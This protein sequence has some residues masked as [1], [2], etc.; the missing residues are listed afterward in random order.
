MSVDPEADYSGSSEDDDESV[1]LEQNLPTTIKLLDEDG[2]VTEEKIGKGDKVKICCGVTPPGGWYG[3]FGCFRISA[4]IF[5]II[6][7]VGA[8]FVILC[9]VG[10]DFWGVMTSLIL[11]VAALMS[12]FAS[13]SHEGIAKQASELGN[14]NK[15]FADKNERFAKQIEALGGVETRLTNVQNTM[16]MDLDQLEDTLDVIHNLT[17]VRELNSML[18]CF[19]DADSVGGNK[20]RVLQGREVQDFFASSDAIL[21]QASPDFDFD[22]M[23]K[24]SLEHGFTIDSLR[25]LVSAV[26]TSSQ[27]NPAKSHAMLDLAMMSVDPENYAEN[28]VASLKIALK[29]KTESA[30]RSLLD[31][32][33]MSEIADMVMT[34]SN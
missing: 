18:R 29:P 1:D 4:F 10:L 26:I 23:K 33:D 30:I 8:V 7:F 34:K 19:T 28:A 22:L 14:Q 11:I 32:E 15:I 17:C 25:L 12:V 9:L 3:P 5:L 20:D 27:K 13:L 24:E 31:Q 2:Q 21:R 16:S 6:A